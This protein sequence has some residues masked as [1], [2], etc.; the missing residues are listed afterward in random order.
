MLEKLF[1]SKAR[2]QILKIFL[3][4]SDDKYYIR[5]LARDLGLQVNSVRRELDNLEKF[6]LL[7]S[8]T[9]VDVEEDDDGGDEEFAELVKGKVVTKKETESIAAKKTTTKQEKKYYQANKNFVLFDEIKA[10][11]M[12]AQVLYEKDF[13]TKIQQAGKPKLLILAGSFVGEKESP[14]D[15]LIVGQ[16]SKTKFAKL[17]QE[18]EKEL[19]RE[20]NYSLMDLTEFKNRRDMTDVFLYSVLEG[21]KVVVIDEVGIE[22]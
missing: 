22:N 10:L 14:V 13:T 4:N 18:L 11:F 12:K 6:G 15:I 20:L 7:I 2:V 8:D 16:V 1:G 9:G 3:L 5:Q 19:N 21:R 17:I